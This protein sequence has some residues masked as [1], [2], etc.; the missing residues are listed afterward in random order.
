F[1]QD[2]GDKVVVTNADKVT[3]TGR[4]AKQKMYYRHSGYPGGLKE[5]SYEKLQSQHPERIIELAVKTMLPDNRLR[6]GWMKRL[7][8]KK[9]AN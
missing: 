3:V 4:K 5:M 9:G 1:H 6:K 8:V 2:N 7:S